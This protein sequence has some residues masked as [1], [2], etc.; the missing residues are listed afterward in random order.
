MTMLFDDEHICKH[1][2]KKTPHLHHCTPAEEAKRYTC[3]YCGTEKI[4]HRHMCKEK[5]QLIQFYCANCGA[6]GTEETHVC[7]P[8]PI[9]KELREQW[10]G[11]AEQHEGEKLLSC[12]VC[13]QPVKSPGHYCDLKYPYIC[14]YCGDKIE[15]GFHFC[16]AKVGKSHYECKT[17]GRIAVNASDLCAPFKFSDD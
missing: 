14:E 11:I 9:A 3:K 7:N 15:K 2:N 8:V 1:C 5:L 10:N 4:N 12:R 16:K 17:C 13:G 6:V